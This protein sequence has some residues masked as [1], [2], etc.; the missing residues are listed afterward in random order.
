MALKTKKR[1]AGGFTII[2][3]EG[4]MEAYDA[5][6]FEG[7]AIGVIDKGKKRLIIDFRELSYISSSGLRALLNIRSRVQKEGGRLALVGL[8]EKVLEVFRVSKLLGIFEVA[9]EAEDIAKG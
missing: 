3:L 4:D 8:K 7:E 5:E 1:E 9:G 2:S 6:A